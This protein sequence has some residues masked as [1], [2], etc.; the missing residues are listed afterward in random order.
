M[1]S[2]LLMTVF[3]V[4]DGKGGV[5]CNEEFYALLLQQDPADCRLGIRGGFQGSMVPSAP[6]LPVSQYSSLMSGL[7]VELA[8]E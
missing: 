3:V 8:A 4:F 7:L 2:M 5:A 1:I 6:L